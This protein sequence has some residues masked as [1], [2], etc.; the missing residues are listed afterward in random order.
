MTAILV[1]MA[2]KIAY[3]VQPPS[4]PSSKFLRSDAYFYL[5][6]AAGGS[7]ILGGPN[8]PFG[9]KKQNGK[10]GTIYQ[11]GRFSVEQHLN[12]INEQ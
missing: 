3:R 5:F 2:T 11:N 1:G 8:I 4:Y 7:E 6:A 9:A 12:N 10:N